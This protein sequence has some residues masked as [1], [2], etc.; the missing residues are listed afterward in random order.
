MTYNRDNSN[1]FKSKQ[2]QKEMAN[3]QHFKDLQNDMGKDGAVLPT[4]GF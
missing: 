2:K 4:K 3:N 1:S